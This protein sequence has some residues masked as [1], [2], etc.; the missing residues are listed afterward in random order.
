MIIILSVLLYFFLFDKNRKYKND[1]I[2]FNKC[3]FY[4]VGIINGKMEIIKCFKS[5]K[6]FVLICGIIIKKIYKD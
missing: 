6:I 3:G 1:I 4:K 2:S 5:D